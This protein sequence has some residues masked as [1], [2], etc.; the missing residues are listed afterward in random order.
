MYPVLPFPM[1]CRM[2]RDFG[3]VRAMIYVNFIFDKL[4]LCMSLKPG[5][6]IHTVFWLY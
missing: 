6:C 1:I 4:G 2:G 5:N 3:N